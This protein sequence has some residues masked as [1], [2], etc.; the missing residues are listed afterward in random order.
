[1]VSLTDVLP[2]T[3]FTPQAVGGTRRTSIFEG[4]ADVAKGLVPDKPK[5]DANDPVLDETA[6]RIFQD[7]T[8][9]QLGDPGYD[10]V[11]FAKRLTNAKRQGT[12]DAT[13]Y[14]I[15]MQSTI[16]D[17]L[18]NNPNSAS[19]IMAKAYSEWGIDHYLFREA[20]DANKMAEGQVSANIANRNSL[21]ATATES[22]RYDPRFQTEDQGLEIGL[23]YTRE[24]ADLAATSALAEAAYQ[25]YQITKG[26]N[27]WEVNQRQNE[28]MR[29]YLHS[30]NATVAA[31]FEQI[32]NL[33][34]AA[35]DDVA[36]EESINSKISEALMGLDA[37][38]VT[39]R[40]F[41]TSHTRD[42][43]GA[44]GTVF[45]IGF[46][47]G[48]RNEW[49]TWIQDTKAMYKE[50][51]SRPLEEKKRFIENWQVKAQL[52]AV[53]RMPALSAFNAGM[54][55]GQWSL[56]FQM[57][58]DPEKY[59][60]DPAD[61]QTLL[62]SAQKGL[63]S[64]AEDS[65]QAL[66]SQ[67]KQGL[68]PSSNP[69]VAV[70][71][72]AFALNSL[73][74]KMQGGVLIDGKF[75][76]GA[77][78]QTSVE[79]FQDQFTDV[80]FAIRKNYTPNSVDV[81][82][83][84]QAMKAALNPR[85][86]QMIGAYETQ[87]G[88]PELAKQF[89]KQSAIA[90]STFIEGL[91]TQGAIEFDA[92]TKRFVPG[93]KSNIGGASGRRYPSEILSPFIEE[94]SVANSLLDFIDMAHVQSPVIDEGL[95][96]NAGLTLR[97][98]IASNGGIEKA[99]EMVVELNEQSLAN[100]EKAAFDEALGNFT[101]NSNPWNTEPAG[102]TMFTGLDPNDLIGTILQREGGWVEDDN[103]AGPSNFGINSR[104]HNMDVEKLR[105]LT[106]DDARDI[107]QK[108]YLDPILEAGVPVEA[109]P[110]VL[111]AAVNQGLD[112]ALKMWELSEGSVD[113]FTELRIARYKNTK[114]FDKYGQQWIDRAIEAGAI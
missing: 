32:Y 78:R 64:Y 46:N 33:T 68:M 103:G 90:A 51:Q 18:R 80:L 28:M 17:M 15:R 6:M 10:Q 70:S 20:Y 5:Q 74:Y 113:R 35:T 12:L 69:N 75:K 52:L 72:A 47:E 102:Q 49:R 88:S 58:S 39:G 11:V 106:E 114:G 21:L 4:I 87:G 93:K 95:L 26:Q 29:T 19:E 97:E 92:T 34:E 59:G 37:L 13:Q 67:T 85:T 36:R 66:T 54:A 1:M 100:Q 96:K 109:Q 110:A 40:N 57:L 45:K 112:A 73:G 53:D 41:M 22:G 79:N 111:D 56:T 30:A 91:R 86:I 25:N 104:A 81:D 38:D 108:E 14:D 77:D 84:K 105:E 2:E 7:K 71:K 9:L 42:F 63:K 94:A 8:G 44:D 60:F 65:M 16:A 23:A 101:F 76:S 99:L 83:A 27:E 24:K 48:A 89:Y 61:T 55:N 3:Q 50:L 82:K 98:A 107:Y 31:N 62:Q 43:Q